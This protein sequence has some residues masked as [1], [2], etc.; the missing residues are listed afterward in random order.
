MHVFIFR[1][2]ALLQIL[3]LD[4]SSIISRTSSFWFVCEFLHRTFTTVTDLMLID[5]VDSFLRHV[6]TLLAI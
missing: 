4:L 5:L 6:S 3:I 2:F 1:F